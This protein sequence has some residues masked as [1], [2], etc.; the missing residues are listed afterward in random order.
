MSEKSGKRWYVVRAISGKEKKVKE[1]LE[2]E[3]SRL[4]LQDFISQILIP[5]EKVF[6]IRKGKKVSKER[7][8][9]PGYVLVEAE[10]TGEIPHIIKNV[11]DVLNFLGTKGKPEPIR[12]AEVMRILGKVDEL[13]EM[14][15]E[16]NIPFIV[17]ESVTVIDGPF[18]SFSGVVEEINHDKKKLKVMVK[19]FGRKT[20]LELGFMQVE[21][22]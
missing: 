16:V 19:I 6:Q 10:L 7:N 9:F 12:E 21:K 17:G 4:N 15:E 11:P 14:G 1:Y 20:P 13:A 8:Y 3:I 5:T 2:S 22:E 18:N